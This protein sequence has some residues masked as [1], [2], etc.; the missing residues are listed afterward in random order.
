M[1]NI[2]PCLKLI[3]AILGLV[4]LLLLGHK[5]AMRL[6]KKHLED[7]PDTMEIIWKQ[8]KYF[9]PTRHFQNR[10]RC[11][12]QYIAYIRPSALNTNLL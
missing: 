8:K 9:S 6:E 12:P 7:E 2:L 10:F 1:N 5:C 11:D 3:A 4:F